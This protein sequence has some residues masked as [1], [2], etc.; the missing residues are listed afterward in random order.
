MDTLIEQLDTKL[1]QWNANTAQ[2]VRQRVAE[3]MDLADHDSLDIGRSRQVEQNVPDMLD[4]P[5]SR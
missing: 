3:I 5:A 1:R 4:E 2:E